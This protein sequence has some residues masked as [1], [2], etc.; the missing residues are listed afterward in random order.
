M[1]IV[2]NEHNLWAGVKDE[3]LARMVDGKIEKE[4]VKPEDPINDV[5]LAGD[6]DPFREQNLK[7]LEQERK[8]KEDRMAII[9]A[10]ATEEVETKA[11]Q[12]RVDQAFMATE[13]ADQALDNAE[14]RM[15]LNFEKGRYFGMST[16]FKSQNNL[17]QEWERI[18]FDEAL[19]L[20][21]KNALE[22]NN[23]DLLGPNDRKLAD[24]FGG[25]LEK[26][27]EVLWFLRF[28]LLCLLSGMRFTIRVPAVVFTGRE[29]AAVCSH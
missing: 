28:L 24:A 7:N 5:R 16:W 14:K 25:N 13:L 29:T 22:T 4:L 12:E 2:P 17:D 23:R 9:A 15:K 21:F 27:I 3:D 6:L 11:E 20:K 8:T 19:K 18:M 26:T 10:K 1:E